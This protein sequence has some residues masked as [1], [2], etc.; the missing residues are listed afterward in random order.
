MPRPGWETWC[1]IQH[2]ERAHLPRLRE[3]LPLPEIGAV[4]DRLPLIADPDTGMEVL[5][6]VYKA[7]FTNPGTPTIAPTAST[8]STAR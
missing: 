6:V 2:S 8:C 5:K 4:L 3:R 1:E 7:G